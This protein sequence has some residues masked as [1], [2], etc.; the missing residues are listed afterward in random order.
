MPKLSKAVRIAE[1]KRR[2]NRSVRHSVKTYTTKA[3][4]LISGGEPETAQ[5]AVVQAVSMIDRAAQKG[6]LHR[7]S[8][9]RRKSRLMKKLNQ[10]AS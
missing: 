10:T 5:S 9:A 8:A 3:Q 7:N 1:K 6:V 2:R 4:K